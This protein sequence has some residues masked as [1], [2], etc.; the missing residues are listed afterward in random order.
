MR[1]VLNTQKI[2]F[3]KMDACQDEGLDLACEMFAT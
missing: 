3:W 2:A 1:L